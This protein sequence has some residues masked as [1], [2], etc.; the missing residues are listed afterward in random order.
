MND[1]AQIFTAIERGDRQAAEQLL[2]LVYDELRRLA[3]RKLARESPGHSLQATALVHEAYLRLV[4]NG[5]GHEWDSQGHFFAAAAQAM[6]QILVDDTR[7]R[8]R[9]SE[10]ADAGG[11]TSMMCL[12]PSQTRTLSLSTRPS[13]GSQVMTRLPRRSSNFASSPVWGTSKSRPRS[14]SRSTSLDRNGVSPEPGSTMCSAAET[15]DGSQRQHK[16]ARCTEAK[17]PG[18]KTCSWR[19]TSNV[20][21]PSSWQ[22]SNASNPQSE[23]RSWTASAG[24]TANC[25]GVSR[26]S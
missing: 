22:P 18:A 5:P 17:A 9:K 8:A 2:P 24:P 1:A 21:R 25:G 15:P 3:A 4:G 13:I 19:L 7:A 16:H 23:P 20:F 14:A 6:R 12:G 26:R 10:A 11:S